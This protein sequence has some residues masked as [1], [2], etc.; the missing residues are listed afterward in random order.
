M[1]LCSNVEVHRFRHTWS[2]YS[3][4]TFK[5]K[6][7][8]SVSVPY[9]DTIYSSVFSPCQ[10]QK[11]KNYEHQCSTHCKCFQGTTCGLSSVVL[12]LVCSVVVKYFCCYI[13]PGSVC[14]GHASLVLL[15]PTATY[16]MYC[17]AHSISEVQRKSN[18][19]H[20]STFFPGM[21][22]IFQW[23]LTC[24]M[25]QVRRVDEGGGE[26]VQHLEGGKV[27]RRWWEGGTKERLNWKT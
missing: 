27:L 3:S 25:S 2:L 7:C 13:W 23:M 21:V 1:S 26:G 6:W 11:V 15:R 24:A 10:L 18:W 12:S 17:I 8:L 9:I 19:K 4:F 22:G 20:N 16:R 14:Y 5:Q